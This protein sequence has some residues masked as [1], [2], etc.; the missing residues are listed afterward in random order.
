MLVAIGLDAIR[1][2]VHHQGANLAAG[3]GADRHRERC[4]GRGPLAHA[5]LEGKDRG[6]GL[7]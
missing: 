7:A 2:D 3:S 5:A 4:D 6:S 1:V